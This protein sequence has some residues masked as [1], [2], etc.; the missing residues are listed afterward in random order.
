MA[1]IIGLIT[2]N[3]KDILE[4]DADPSAGLGTPAPVASL[5][6]WDNAGVGNV[7][8][9]TGAADTAWNTFDTTPSWD[10]VGNTLTGGTPATPNEFFGST[11][12]YD[13]TFRR[14]NLE[15]M[16]LVNGALLVGLSASLGG[17]LQIN[18]ATAGADLM[19]EILD[20]AGSTPIINV[21]RMFRV[22]TT[23]ATPATFNIAVPN[24]RNAL[25]NVSA[26]VRQTAG[27]TGAIG[28]GAS[29][30]RTLHASNVGGTVSIFKPQTDYTYEVAGGLNL[31]AVASG[32]NVEYSAQG[33][34]NRSLTWGVRAT[35]L[36]TNT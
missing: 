25:I 3:G 8:F 35:L 16:R 22:T 31:S 23:N 18:D 26:C 7:Y 30:Q 32:A 20:A 6:M 19:K 10:L 11:N 29:Y 15:Q 36:I 24:D 17:R 9:K 14:N 33:A 4:V 28:D 21:S 2:V 13:V 5:A 1:N 12:D 27:S 34:T